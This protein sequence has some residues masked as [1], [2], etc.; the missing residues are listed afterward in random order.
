MDLE[1]AAMICAHACTGDSADLAGHAVIPSISLST[2]FARSKADYAPF[3][4]KKGQDLV[5]ARDNSE[6]SKQCEEV[7]KRLER[8]EDA[9]L[10]ASG[11]AC[12]SAVMNALFQPDSVVFFP[13]RSYYQNRK[14]F[15]QWCERMRVRLIS[16]DTDE[17]SME[18]LKMAMEMVKEEECEKFLWVETPANSSWE[19]CDI[20][21]TC[22][23]AK[24]YG[25][26]SFV[27]ATCLTPLLCQPLTI[28]ADFVIHSCSKYLNGHSDVLAGVISCKNKESDEWKKIKDARRTGGAMCSP[29]D[30]WLLLRGMRTLHLRVPKACSNAMTVANAMSKFTFVVPKNPL[31]TNDV[32]DLQQQREHAVMEQQQQPPPVE[33]KKKEEKDLSAEKEISQQL[34]EQK[35]QFRLDVKYPGLAEHVNHAVAKKQQAGHRKN[36]FGGMLSI[37]IVPILDVDEK[38]NTDTGVNGTKEDAEAKKDKM[39]KL[40]F[41]MAKVVAIS[42]KIWKPAT[43][44]GGPESLI[45]HRASVEGGASSTCP[46]GLLR[47]SCGLEPGQLLSKDLQK[48]LRDAYEIVLTNPPKPPPAAEVPPPAVV[49]PPPAA[50]VPPELPVVAVTENEVLKPNGFNNTFSNLG[51]A[52]ANGVIYPNTNENNKRSFPGEP[53]SLQPVGDL[54]LSIPVGSLDDP[55]IKVK[56]PKNILIPKEFRCTQTTGKNRCLRARLEGSSFCE[57]HGYL[58]DGGSHKSV[59]LSSVT[60]MLIGEVKAA[61]LP[62]P[63]PFQSEVQLETAPTQNL[64][65][66]IYHG[67]LDMPIPL[68]ITANGKANLDTQQKNTNISKHV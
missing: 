67:D 23:W 34:K 57:R 58:Q 25:V 28:G 20:E 9:L 26:S 16:Y 6:N 65:D 14:H 22:M 4:T 59:P 12:C 37:V 60:P 33:E 41:E 40:A 15:E 31:I 38:N 13:K 63:E 56:K 61:G 51:A 53:T 32:G 19:V 24:A 29:F 66:G 64:N 30:S 2:T 45:E 43:S 36:L 7:I 39:N 49:V 47:L 42:T 55:Q 18:Y 27:D 52:V 62:A 5:Y 44:L 21:R 46:H 10:F 8:A 48:A 3:Q 1:K 35:P 11:M 17:Q 68:S 54:S 50:V